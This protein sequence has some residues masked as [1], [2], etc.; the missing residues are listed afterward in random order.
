MFTIH[1]NWASS[2]SGAFGLHAF[3]GIISRHHDVEDDVD[4]LILRLPKATIKYNAGQHF[5][6]TF[7][8]VSLFES[9]PFTPARFC[10]SDNAM[11]FYEQLYIIRVHAGQTRHLAKYCTEERVEY[12]LP[13]VCCGP[14][15]NEILDDGAQNVQLIAGGTGVSFTLPL[16]MKIVAEATRTQ[17]DTPTVPMS[18]RLDF[19]WIIRRGRNINWIKEELRRLKKDSYDVHVDLRI[20]VFVTREG[21]KEKSMSTLSSPSPSTS[22]LPATD[23]SSE[24]PLHKN[25]DPVQLRIET[26]PS[27]ISKEIHS[28]PS[29]GSVTLIGNRTQETDWLQDHHPEV[30]DLVREFWEQRC[31]DGRVQVLASGPPA[32]ANELHNAVAGCNDYGMVRRGEER[33]DVSIHWDA[34]E[35]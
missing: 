10:R 11:P 14:Y 4:V 7:P 13:I 35:Y 12:P 34:R 15:G 28:M 9:H 8:T 31:V 17:S 32:M 23:G 6:L 21:Q 26:L 33:G 27:T 18:R 22:S 20:R 30:R 25:L 24:K 3:Q 19:V 16:A 1:M 29:P 5:F 2:E